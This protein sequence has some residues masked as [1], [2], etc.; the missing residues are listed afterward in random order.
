MTDE[1]IAVQICV[2]GFIRLQEKH[3]SLSEDGKC[4][5]KKELKTRTPLYMRK[6]GREDAER[7]Q[8]LNLLLEGCIFRKG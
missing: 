6:M 4:S 3:L 8:S 2:N 7:E 1:Y 5:L